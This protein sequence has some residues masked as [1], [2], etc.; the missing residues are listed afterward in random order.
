MTLMSV[1]YGNIGRSI[2]DSSTGI[3]SSS[4]LT[5]AGMV[6]GMVAHMVCK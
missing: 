5:Q 3:A 6:G 4:E 1:R 2:A